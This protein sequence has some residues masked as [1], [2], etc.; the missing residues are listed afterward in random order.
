MN[1]MW[2]PLVGSICITFILITYFFL[3]S[4][5]KSEVQKTIRDALDKG[6]QLTPEIIEKMSVVQSPKVT[7]LR[8]G[9]VLVS[10]GIAVF[11]A[12]WVAGDFKNTSP[13][14]MFPLMLGIGFLSVWKIN[15][16]D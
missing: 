12:G 6:N 2:I 16:Y 10:L 14:G 7:D 1:G 11:L 8:R 4:R 9:I 15:K 5:D 13:I 3:K